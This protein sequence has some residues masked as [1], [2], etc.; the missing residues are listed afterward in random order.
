MITI[1]NDDVPPALMKNYSLTAV[2]AVQPVGAD[3][4]VGDIIMIILLI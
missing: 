4:K 1:R 2:L 3:S